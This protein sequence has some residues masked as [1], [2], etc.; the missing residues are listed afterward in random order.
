[1]STPDPTGQPSPRDRLR[2]RHDEQLMLLSTFL[3]FDAKVA[4]ARATLDALEADQRTALAELAAATSI[5]IAA[6]LTGVTPARVRDALA[7]QRRPAAPPD[8]VRG[9]A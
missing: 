7:G 8:T 3:G 5:D 1:M 9:A 6:D 4:R 2:A